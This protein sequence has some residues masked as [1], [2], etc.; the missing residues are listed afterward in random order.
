MHD[1]PLHALAAAVNEPDLGKPFRVR[2]VQV[3]LDDGGDVSGRKAV[4]IDRVLDRQDGDFVRVGQGFLVG[5]VGLVGLGR[6][7]L[8]PG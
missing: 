4:E 5:L 8:S 3:F 2:L 6:V 1:A 7:R